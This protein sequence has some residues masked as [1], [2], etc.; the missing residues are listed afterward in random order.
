MRRRLLNRLLTRASAPGDTGLA[1]QVL[2]SLARAVPRTPSG[3]RLVRELHADD[4][5]AA[6]YLAARVIPRFVPDH[7]AADEAWHLLLRLADD[8]AAVVRQGAAFGLGELAIA[9]S[10]AR[11]LLERLLDDA[12]RPRAQRR[13]ALR[14]LTLLAV[15]PSTEDLAERLL[16][17]AVLADEGLAPGAEVVV[18]RGIG[19]RDRERA[20]EILRGWVA[21]SEPILRRHGARGIE[22]LREAPV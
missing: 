3:A 9:E 18:T 5:W 15:T 13:A 22:R 12:A 4:R 19:P 16:R 10:D 17:D 14:S 20:L 1:S 8:D 21:S 11:T 2:P 7:L 6:R